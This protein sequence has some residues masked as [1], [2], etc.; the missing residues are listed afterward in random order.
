MRNFAKNQNM[1]VHH[2]GKFERLFF[3]KNS[4][5]IL[6]LATRDLLDKFVVSQTLGDVLKESH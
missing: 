2:T 1:S 5:L 4:R 6:D 3:K